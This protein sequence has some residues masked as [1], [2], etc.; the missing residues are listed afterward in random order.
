MKFADF[1]HALSRAALAHYSDF[2]HSL[3]YVSKT[4]FLI[5]QLGETVARALLF[6]LVR[7]LVYAPREDRIPEFKDYQSTLDNWG[8]GDLSSPD[9]E[10]WHRQG[11][12]SALKTTLA[13]SN[14]EPEDIFR[15]LL[16][17]NATAM[18][19]F[20]IEQQNKINVSVSGNVGWLDFSH[21][22][23]FANAVHKQCSQFPKLWPRGLLQMTCFVGRNS[24]FTSHSINHNEWHIS[25]PEKTLKHFIEDLFNHGQG[26][27]IVSVHLLKT[28]L[29][30][31]EEIKGL[32]DS[33]IQILLA[34]LNRFLNSPL[35][36]TLP[37]RTAHQSLQFVAKES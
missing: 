20:N 17:A 35:K 10:N 26:E 14:A 23:T 37:R 15:E 36:R 21:G 18:L 30:V 4:G 22:L 2:G 29:A 6:S 1:E 13:C 3:I 12:A 16:L 32:E 25:N 27:A 8:Q 24:A 5:D 9:A 28:T 33:E 34:A 11:I 19:E 7:S 31:R